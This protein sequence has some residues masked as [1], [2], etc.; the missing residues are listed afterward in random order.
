M[1]KERRKRQ[2]PGKAAEK[3]VVAKAKAA[4]TRRTPAVARP[5]PEEAEDAL[6]DPS[7]SSLSIACIGASAGGLEAITQVLQGL[8]RDPG[9]ALVL[10][11]G[12]EEELHAQAQPDDRHARIGS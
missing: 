4:S 2:G 12:L 11:R 6:V 5:A 8:D 10:G 9:L 1:K 7:A 3:K